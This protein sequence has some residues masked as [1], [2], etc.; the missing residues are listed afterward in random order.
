MPATAIPA[1]CAAGC[2]TSSCPR[3]RA[4]FPER[5]TGWPPWRCAGAISGRGVRWSGRVRPGT[6]LSLP[7][8]A[9]RAVRS[10]C[11]RLARMRNSRRPFSWMLGVL[12]VLVVLLVFYG[13]SGPSSTTE[14][15]GQLQQAVALWET[16]HTAPLAI[17]N[18]KRTQISSDGSTVTWYDN[19][20]HLYTTT[21]G[22]S[23]Q[24]THEFQTA[25]YT[26]YTNEGSNLTKILISLLPTLVLRS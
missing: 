12:L 25:G 6:S 14:T 9:S 5:A 19:R 4:S 11:Y 22:D 18:S 17:S 10:P 23:A 21:V 3:W 1:S 8:R 7:D 16:N 26:N 20:G 24:A 13:R 2:A 15:S